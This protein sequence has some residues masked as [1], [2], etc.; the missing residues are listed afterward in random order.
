MELVLPIRAGG[1]SGSPKAGLACDSSP[2]SGSLTDY[3]VRTT[4]ERVPG[5]NTVFTT[6]DIVLVRGGAAGAPAGS[7]AD[8][9]LD[10]E[11]TTGRIVDYG[12]PTGP[13]LRYSTL[14]GCLLDAGDLADIPDG[15][16][17]VGTVDEGLAD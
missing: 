11:D 6:H 15:D 1:W 4:A 7:S 12:G 13:L 10:G 16:G 5:K 14:S 17:T 2:A 9:L 3:L 8:Q